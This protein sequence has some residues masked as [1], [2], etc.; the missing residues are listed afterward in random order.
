MCP[1]TVRSFTARFPPMVRKRSWTEKWLLIGRVSIPFWKERWASTAARCHSPRDR[2]ALNTF[3]S[4]STRNRRRF[5]SWRLSGKNSGKATHPSNTD[6][7]RSGSCKIVAAETRLGAP[8]AIFEKTALQYVGYD[9]SWIDLVELTVPLAGT[10]AASEQPGISATNIPHRG[11]GALA[12]CAG[13]LPVAKL[14]L[15]SIRGTN[16]SSRVLYLDTIPERTKIKRPR[17]ARPVA[18][19]AAHP[20]KGAPH[21]NRVADDWPKCLVVAS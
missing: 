4:R 14:T 16:T 8:L 9:S 13:E 18:G 6:F 12:G 5:L 7:V 15:K 2:I 21:H 17:G 3:I 10:I 20:V 11:Q 1:R 19:G